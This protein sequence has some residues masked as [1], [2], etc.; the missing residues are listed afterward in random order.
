MSDRAAT[1]AAAFAFA[2]PATGTWGAGLVDSADAVSLV[3][4]DGE[5]WTS[6]TGALRRSEPEGRWELESDS[7][8]L[9]LAPVPDAPVEADSLAQAPA[10]TAQAP[11][12]TA[13]APAETAQ[14]PAETAAASAGTAAARARTA[15]SLCH[16]SGHIALSGQTREVTCIG[17]RQSPS[18]L[19]DS[20]WASARQ[21]VAWFASDDGVALTALR[22]PKARA[23]GEDVVHGEILGGEPSDV[24]DPRLST[25]YGPDGSPSRAGL[26]L[27]IGRPEGDEL[28]PV[29]AAGEAAGPGAV[30]DRADQQ[31][32]VRPFRWHSR[33]RE[34]AGIYLL[35]RRA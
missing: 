10:E 8:S 13:Q 1:E 32:T 17:W 3:L 23:Q 18:L 21:V 30:L 28:H 14:A 4:G 9:V 25:T 15:D 12:E 31:V 34:G 7:S 29:R 16:V 33:G 24:E 2:D 19:G 6:A 22:P 11:A 26:E 27:W 20:D 35:R 5:T